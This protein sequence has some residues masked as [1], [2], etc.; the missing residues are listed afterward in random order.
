MA[1]VIQAHPKDGVDQLRHLLLREARSI[2]HEDTRMC[3]L[4]AFYGASLFKRD[5]IN[6]LTICNTGA[7]ATGGIGTAF[8]VIFYLSRS[9][10]NVHVYVCETRPLL[11][12]ARLT[13][14]ELLKSRIRAT[15]ICDS[16][17]AAL[18]DQKKIEAVIVGADRIASNGD[19]ANKVGTYGLSVL[20]KV[21]RI[22]FY[23]A[24]PY[25]TFDMRL[26]NGQQIPIEERTADEVI[27]PRGLIF[28]PR[29]TYVYNPAFDVTPASNI[30]AFI[31][32]KGVIYPPFRRKILGYAGPN[33]TC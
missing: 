14:F 27:T 26:S 31:T 25:S 2:H 20:A 22:P 6:I 33:K 17:A 7:L 29:G 21:H 24:A 5:K 3:N 1:R 28:A 30:T 12:G 19:T 11:Q 8:G 13:M 10:K 18:M 23:I 4:I 9:G 16:V 15:L 32:E